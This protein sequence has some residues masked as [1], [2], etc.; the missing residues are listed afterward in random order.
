MILVGCDPVLSVALITLSLGMNGAST[1]TNLQNNQDLAPSFAG[2]I[3]GIINCFGG[4]TG[5]IT[6]VLTGYL[7]AERV[8]YTFCLWSNYLL[9]LSLEWIT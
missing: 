6:P 4:T 9:F 5:F 2:T 1:I 8:S 3:Y 7:T